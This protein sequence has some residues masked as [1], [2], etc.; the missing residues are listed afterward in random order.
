MGAGAGYAMATGV[1][2]GLGGTLGYLPFLIEWIPAAA[3]APILIYI[4]L[5]VLAQAFTATPARHAA[6]VS[7]AVLPSIA[8]LISLEIGAVLP[9]GVSLTGE[10]AETVG[11]LRLLASGFIVTALLWGSAAANLIDGRFLRSGLF[12]FGAALLCLFGVIHS[13]APQGTLFFPWQ[14]G[15]V[16]LQLAAGYAILGL[17][18]LVPALALSQRHGP[19]ESP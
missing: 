13:P 11:T 19:G 3:V 2:V 4:G 9:A 17:I 6:A 7:L 5:E 18:L 16:S 8:F 12:F 10:T 15:A 14:A 1:F